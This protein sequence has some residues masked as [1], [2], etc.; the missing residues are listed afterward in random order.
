MTQ[1]QEEQL[2]KEKIEELLNYVINSKSDEWEYISPKRIK[3]KYQNI[4]MHTDNN[5]VGDPSFLCNGIEISRCEISKFCNDSL[6]YE[7][8]KDKVRIIEIDLNYELVKDN[9]IKF[10]NLGDKHE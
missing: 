9:M 3:S 4:Y 8:A 1:E 7:A 6:L 5:N 10:F 2:I